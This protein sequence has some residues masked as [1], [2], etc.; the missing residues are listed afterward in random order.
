MV[1]VQEELETRNIYLR[2]VG[3]KHLVMPVR[4]EL[5]D[6]YQN[7]VGTINLGVSLE[8]DKHAIHMSR[9]V[10]SLY[11]WD[12]TISNE[13]IKKL[14]LE[15]KKRLEALTSH[16][17]IEFIFFKDKIAPSSKLTGTMDY[18]CMIKAELFEDD[19]MNFQI[20]VKVPIGSVCPCS[21]AIS[22]YGAHNQRGTVEV[23]FRSD[24]I[25]CLNDIINKIE[26][27]ASTQLYSLLKRV[28]EKYVTEYAYENPKFV[29]DI[30][31]DVTVQLMKDQRYS[32]FNIAVENY[33]SIHN[34]NAYAV[35]VSEDIG[36]LKRNG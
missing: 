5:N 12:S 4:H 27:V 26:S 7:S 32:W 23:A 16:I 1:D 15:V 31:R 30:A 3:I 2:K 10:E 33:E 36:G 6:K 17:E 22:K 24:D 35:S 11:Q 21:K 29:E 25:G 28:D 20:I 9:L 19:S 14:L 18:N 34:H 8:A 13:S